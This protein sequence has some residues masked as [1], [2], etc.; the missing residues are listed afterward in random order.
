MQL[1]AAIDQRARQVHHMAFAA[2]QA[3]CGTNL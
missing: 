1:M 3:F 2:P